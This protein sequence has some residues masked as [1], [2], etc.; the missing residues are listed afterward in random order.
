MAERTIVIR[1]SVVYHGLS[2]GSALA[3]ILSFGKNASILWAI[4]HGLLSWL[5]VIYYALE[6]GR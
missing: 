4:V 3:M 2:M 5:Y 6:T 1:K